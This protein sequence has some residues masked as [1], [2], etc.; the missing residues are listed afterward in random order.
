MQEIKLLD[1]FLLEVLKQ[2]RGKSTYFS[3][4]KD[5]LQEE[6]KSMQVHPVLKAL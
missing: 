2:Q 4:Q 5:I 3:S 1:R 6:R